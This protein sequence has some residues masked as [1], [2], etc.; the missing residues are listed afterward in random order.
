MMAAKDLDFIIYENS[1]SQT[2]LIPFYTFTYGICLALIV[3]MD[4]THC[5]RLPSI[6]FNAAAAAGSILCSVRVAGG[7]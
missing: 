6:R 7:C 5:S 3:H 2:D 1:T 4:A